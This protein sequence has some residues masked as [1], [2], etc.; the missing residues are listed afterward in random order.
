MVLET[1]NDQPPQCSYQNTRPRHN[2]P[3]IFEPRYYKHIGLNEKGFVFT[4]RKKP[5]NSV[6]Q[7]GLEP[8][9]KIISKDLEPIQ[10]KGLEP[11]SKRL[12]PIQKKSLEPISKGSKKTFRSHFKPLRVCDVDLIDKARDSLLFS[13]HP[14][15][16][17]KP[18]Q[19]REE[20]VCIIVINICIYII[21][22]GCRLVSMVIGLLVKHLILIIL[23]LRMQ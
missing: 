10:N 23:N 12:E 9:Q 2:K 19:H 18:Y 8:I 14:Y 13:S 3:I 16:N 15:R 22:I 20:V 21:I 1:I 11:I 6:L 4:D 17:Y 5:K 7:K